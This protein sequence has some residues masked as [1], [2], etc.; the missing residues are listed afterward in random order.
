MVATAPMQHQFTF[1]VESKDEILLPKRAT[2]GSAGYD[3]C[4]SDALTVSAGAR[5][6]IGTGV[7]IAMTTH[8]LPNDTLVYGAIKGRS[9]LARKGIT[10]FHGT[11]DSDYRGEIKLILTNNSADDYRIEYGDKVAQI[12]FELALTPLL[13]VHADVTSEFS[14]ARGDGGFGSTDSSSC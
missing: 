2:E 5:V 4:S 1:A 10:I 12:V 3:L 7:K 14:T 9:S 11:I 13:V 8:T 6:M